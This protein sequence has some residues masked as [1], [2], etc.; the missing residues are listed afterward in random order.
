MQNTL[1]LA[2]P[3][4]LQGKSNPSP[5]WDFCKFIKA[6]GGEESSCGLV[7]LPKE[8]LVILEKVLFCK[9]SLHRRNQ[10]SLSTP[11]K[12]PVKSIIPKSGKPC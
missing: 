1:V 5:S 11:T 2:S 9:A 7:I 12:Q 3:T 10:A 8:F 6:C 4:V